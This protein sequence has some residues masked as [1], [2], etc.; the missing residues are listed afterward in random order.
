MPPVSRRL[1]LAG[2]AA[3]GA[4]PLLSP[5][6][7]ASLAA[8]TG[9]VILSVSGLIEERN[10]GEMAEFDLDGL[11]ALG[12]DTIET[13]TPWHPETLRYQGVGTKRFVEA[14]K[15][16]GAEMRAIALND[17]AVTVPFADLLGTGAMLATRV[18]GEPLRVRDKGPIWLIY[19]W[20]QRPELDTRVHHTRSIWQIRRL[21]FS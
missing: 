4:L 21:Q 1:L 7:K 16:R 6:A 13:A 17:Y 3:C 19:P 9:R 12:L 8:P 20:S 11:E 15:A 2:L 18:G 10:R 5:R 14:V